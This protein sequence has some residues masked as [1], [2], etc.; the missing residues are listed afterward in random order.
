[1]LHRFAV[2][3]SNVFCDIHN[4]Y[5]A[6]KKEEIAYG[7]EIGLST[8]LTISIVII[9]STFFSLTKECIIF[10]LTFMP[11]RTYTGGYHATTHLRCFICL[12]IDM[13]IGA[14]CKQYVICEYTNIVSIV[15]II[16]TIIVVVVFAPVVDK[17]HPLSKRQVINSRIKSLKILI[18]LV[19]FNIVLMLLKSKNLSLSAS[20]GLASVAM[21]IIIAKFKRRRDENEEVF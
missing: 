16:I 21:S 1:M 15:M 10:L 20:Y 4:T 8:I 7:L 19:A 14:I 5:S 2:D 11:L 6:D 9:I 3:I 18:M 13:A 17:N 12:M